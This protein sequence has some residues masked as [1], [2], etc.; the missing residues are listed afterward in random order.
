MFRKPH[1]IALVAV[2]LLVV[3]VLNLPQR[4]VASAKFAISSLF[5]PLFGLVGLSH[6]AVEQTANALTPRKAL[7][8]ELDY[9]RRENARLHEEIRQG[10]EVWRENQRLRAANSLQPKLPWPVKLARVAGRDPANW[11]RMVYI[12]LGARDGLRP[13]MPIITGEGLVG[14][15][16]EVELGQSRVLLVGDPNCRVPALVQ[17][18]RD[19]TGI[20]TGS[21]PGSFD[22]QMVD[23]TYLPLN[24]DIK[25]GQRVVTSGLG[26]DF[27]P[28]IIIGKLADIRSV[29]HGLYQEARVILAA[30]L[31]QLEEVWVVMLPASRTLPPPAPAKGK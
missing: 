25:A 6:Q 27:P 5:L 4:A 31:N 11:W 8:Q 26:V 30:N 14:K 23:L 18:T 28:G 16:V 3:I 21:S 17:E 15:V 20:V 2:V 19:N 10:Q 29:G 12:D 1:L 7:I 9:L 24:P 13:D 22:Y